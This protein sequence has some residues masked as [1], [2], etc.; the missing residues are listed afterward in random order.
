MKLTMMVKAVMK[1]T[2]MTMNCLNRCINYDYNSLGDGQGRT[3]KFHYTECGDSADGWSVNGYTFKNFAKGKFLIDCSSN[4]NR[5][6][7]K[8]NNNFVKTD[9]KG[10][11]EHPNWEDGSEFILVRRGDVTKN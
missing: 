1:S 8:D 6:V 2:S 7:L 10:N 5:S 9:N 4:K 11:N 3:F